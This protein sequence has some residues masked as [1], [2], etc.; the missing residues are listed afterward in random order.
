MSDSVAVQLVS[1]N[2]SKFQMGETVHQGADMDP[3]EFKLHKEFDQPTGSN[4]SR[5]TKFGSY[6]YLLPLC[7]ALAVFAVIAV[8]LVGAVS[9]PYAKV[10]AL[11]IFQTDA[12]LNVGIHKENREV[13]NIKWTLYEE[14]A[15][16]VQTGSLFQ[17]NE[18]AVLH[19]LSENTDYTFLVTGEMNLEEIE[20][21]RFA[22][23][24]AF[25]PKRT[26]CRRTETGPT[27]KEVK[28]CMDKHG[29][30]IPF[31]QVVVHNSSK[32]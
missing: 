19:D 22:F 8:L 17:L 23:T 2:I 29:I 14:G 10:T 26:G 24:S 4:Q 5:R 15:E 20:L 1:V 7:S 31:T 16:S 12:V 18:N 32:E 30:E 28:L 9:D 6:T 3:R 25:R 21:T 13:K 11:S 27:D